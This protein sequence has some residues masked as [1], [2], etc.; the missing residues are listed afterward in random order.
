MPLCPPARS[1]AAAAMRTAPAIVCTCAYSALSAHACLAD[2]HT[3]K[4]VVVDNHQ[5]KANFWDLAGAAEYFEVRN[6]FYRDAQGAI[7][8]TVPIATPHNAPPRA[9]ALAADAVYRSINTSI[10][11]QAASRAPRAPSSRGQRAHLMRTD[12]S[13]LSSV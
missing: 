12:L 11:R 8:G 13:F 9:P 1:Q 3:V 5:V 7:L 6:E 10:A 4:S 2:C